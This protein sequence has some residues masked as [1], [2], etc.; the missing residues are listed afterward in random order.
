MYATRVAGKVRS[1]TSSAAMEYRGY[2]AGVYDG[3]DVR[4]VETGGRA[5]RL[6][7]GGGGRCG[8]VHGARARRCGGAGA[9]RDRA[10]EGFP[11]RSAGQAARAGGETRGGGRLD[12]GVPDGDL[13]NLV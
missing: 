2:T 5:D 4:P 7:R 13:R 6:R 1:S 12:V 10:V 8:G 11:L 3:G 9:A